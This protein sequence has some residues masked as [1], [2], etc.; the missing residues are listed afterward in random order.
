MEGVNDAEP[1]NDIVMI[2]IVESDSNNVYCEE[3]RA[4]KR[5]KRYTETEIREDTL[6][7]TTIRTE[8]NPESPCGQS[9]NVK[10]RVCPNG[11]QCGQKFLNIHASILSFRRELWDDQRTD[12]IHLKASTNYRKIK[13][14]KM[15][16]QSR[17]EDQS[18]IENDG[19][20]IEDA[21]GTNALLY[22]I[23]LHLIKFAY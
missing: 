21:P 1:R 12:R 3:I 19:R 18:R 9:R 6:N 20:R 23:I 7:M 13:L 14:F 22:H 15:L 11:K 5:R 4:P 17:I 16:Y 2:E 8:F 10:G